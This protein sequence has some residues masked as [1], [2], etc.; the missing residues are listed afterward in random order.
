MPPSGGVAQRARD[1]AVNGRFPSGLA[2]AMHLARRANVDRR[3]ESTPGGKCNAKNGSWG[4]RGCSVGDG[5]W[6]R[7]EERGHN[8][9]SGAGAGTGGRSERERARGWRGGDGDGRSKGGDR[10][11]VGSEDDRRRDRV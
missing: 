7:S 3:E 2:R 6:W 9:S 4:D 8:R 11:D 1:A 5:V 10:Q